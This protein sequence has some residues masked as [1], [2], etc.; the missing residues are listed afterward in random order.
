MEVLDDYGEIDLVGAD[1]VSLEKSKLTL[2]YGSGDPYYN[3]T[4]Q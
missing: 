2:D 4:R 3:L 1:F